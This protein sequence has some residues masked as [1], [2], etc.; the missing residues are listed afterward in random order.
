V[1]ALD[2]IAKVE[3]RARRLVYPRD[4]LR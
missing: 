3:Q 2:E 1:A 4:L